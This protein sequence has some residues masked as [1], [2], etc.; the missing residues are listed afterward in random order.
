LVEANGRGDSCRGDPG[1]DLR[2]VDGNHCGAVGRWWTDGCQCETGHAGPCK[3]GGEEFGAPDAISAIVIELPIVK[4]KE[5][6][7]ICSEPWV[8]KFAVWSLSRKQ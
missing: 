8:S 6:I 5:R 4:R 3:F 7:P 2:L 1:F